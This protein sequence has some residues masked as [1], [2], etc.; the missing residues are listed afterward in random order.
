VP[1]PRVNLTRYHG[2][3]APNHRWRGL[4][5]P[6]RR[7]KGIK[8]IS[9]VEVR[10]TAERHAAM[11]WAQRLKRVLMGR[12]S[13]SISRSAPAAADLSESSSRR[14]TAVSRS[15]MSYPIKRG[16][17]SIEFWLILRERNRTPPPC[18]TWHHRPE[19]HLRQGELM[20]SIKR[21][22]PGVHCLFSLGRI[23][24]QQHYT[25]KEASEYRMA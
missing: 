21:G 24:A 22:C 19:H 1:K 5:T 7:G 15:K 3:L 6:A 11:T 23:P 2:I 9:N 16:R 25:S 17:P 13:A 14:R 12:P 18:H 8:P 10:S 4:V 20:R